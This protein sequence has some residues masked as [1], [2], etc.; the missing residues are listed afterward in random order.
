MEIL[1]YLHLKTRRIINDI[2]F[3]QKQVGVTLA[4]IQLRQAQH[5]Q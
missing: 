3:L 2:K 5:K 1:T 4:R